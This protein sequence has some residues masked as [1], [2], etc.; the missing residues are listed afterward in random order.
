MSRRTLDYKI[1][2]G[3]VAV[4]LLLATPSDA[5]QDQS[6]K[7]LNDNSYP[8]EASIRYE[9]HV[10]N[11]GWMTAV[12]DGETAGTEGMGVRL[13]ALRIFLDGDSRGIDLEYRV[14]APGLGWT[15]WITSGGIAG[16]TGQQQLLDAL[17][18]RLDGASPGQSIV[19][20]VHVQDRGWLDW[21]ADGEVAG[22]PDRHL[23]IEAV[24][25]QLANHDKPAKEPDN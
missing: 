14:H 9:A 11:H 16:T 21:V 8:N 10:Q 24:R 2:I 17:Q 25:I 22:D 7:P 3:T 1:A 18:I 12:S 6:K 5:G 20:Q 19:Y 13:E 4:L 23:R 15:A